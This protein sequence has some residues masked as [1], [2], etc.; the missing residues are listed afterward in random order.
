MAAGSGGGGFK[1]IITEDGGA[2]IPL[3]SSR[4][5]SPADCCGLAWGVDPR[6]ANSR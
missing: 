4:R 6:M 1:D 5:S 3:A 2:E